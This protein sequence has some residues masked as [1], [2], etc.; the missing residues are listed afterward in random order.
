MFKH[1][2]VG[3]Y[4]TRNFCGIIHTWLVTDVTPDLI[5][6]GMGWTFDPETGAEVD[7]GLQWGPK[8]GRTGSYL[9]KES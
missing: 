1:L 2:K 9:I 8:F 6:I 7:E 3:D 5:T 4:A